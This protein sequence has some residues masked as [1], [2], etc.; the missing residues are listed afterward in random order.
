MVTIVYDIQINKEKT[1]EIIIITTSRNA[2][3]PLFPNIDPVETF[4]LSI[5]VSNDPK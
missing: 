5:M 1:K 4:K 3:V 2:S